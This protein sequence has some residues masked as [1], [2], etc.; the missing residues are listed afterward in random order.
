MN[1]SP[2]EC[3]QALE[4][5]AA[6]S[7]L[8]DFYL[9]PRTPITDQIQDKIRERVGAADLELH[10]RRSRPRRILAHLNRLLQRGL[11]SPQFT[12]L[13]IACG[14]AAVLWQIKRAFP[15]AVCF[16]FDCHKG[17]FSLHERVQQDGVQ[18]FRGFLQ[19]LFERN[20]SP[21]FDVVLMLNTYRGWESADLRPHEQDLPARADVWL[22]NNARFIVL[23]VTR[24]QLARFRQR[25]LT[26]SN[27]GRGED[28]SVLACFSRLPQPHSWWQRLL[29]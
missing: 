11:L 1:C 13:D 20:I 21:P 22:E 5:R 12:V 28:K 4:A 14:D 15:E 8:A 7:D 27:L 10:H 25:G 17:R 24:A 23:T 2:T 6:A 16:G 9:W 26:V 19:H 3:L 18:L 29:T